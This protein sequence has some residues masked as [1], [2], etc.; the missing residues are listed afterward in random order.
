[1][2]KEIKDH[3]DKVVFNNGI[4]DRQL[5]FCNGC[6]LGTKTDCYPPM[7][8]KNALRILKKV[9]AEKLLEILK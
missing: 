7:A 6:P 1:M 9:K 4:C 2:T 5:S 8:L 3:I